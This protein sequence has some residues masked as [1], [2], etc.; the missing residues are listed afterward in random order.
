MIISYFIKVLN[1]I[2]ILKI[3]IL[4]PKEEFIKKDIKEK[5]NMQSL[6]V[7]ILVQKWTSKYMY[8]CINLYLLI[9]SWLFIL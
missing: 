6:E 5:L 7:S 9:G 3:L 2:V 4:L 8:L 1:V